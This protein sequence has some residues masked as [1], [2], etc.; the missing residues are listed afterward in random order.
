MLEFQ[1]FRTVQAQ[2]ANLTAPLY[3]K[4]VL[5]VYHLLLYYYI[6]VQVERVPSGRLIM[7][8]NLFNSWD[9]MVYVC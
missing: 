7:R 4:S 1:T 3:S 2:N 6:V 8:V 5:P 9:Q